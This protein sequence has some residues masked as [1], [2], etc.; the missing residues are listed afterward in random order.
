MITNQLPN[1]LDLGWFN[2]DR[3]KELTIYLG[4][5]SP[6][7]SYSAED[8]I[9]SFVYT[10]RLEGLNTSIIVEF[11]PSKSS[12]MLG[13]VTDKHPYQSRLSK[14]L[15]CFNYVKVKDLLNA[16]TLLKSN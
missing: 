9:S 11:N 6:I 2:K 3:H 12:V 4:F 5:D 7:I 1:E 10:K 8:T 16:F 14:S 15:G 13:I